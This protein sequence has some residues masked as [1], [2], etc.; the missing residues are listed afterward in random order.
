[1]RG[2][3]ARVRAWWEAAGISAGRSVVYM[4]E[5]VA[6][7][8]LENLVHMSR[9][10]FP[11]GYVTVA[12]QLPDSISLLAEDALRR[13]PAL[14]ALSPTELGNWWLES[15]ASAV[16]KV[17]SVVVRGA[18]NYL[19]NPQHPEFSLIQVEPPAIFH[20]DERLFA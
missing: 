16:L 10:D 15:Q 13:T 9:R 5:S 20:F 12:A 14:R 19:L 7:A 4:A 6:L 8:V 11:T 2:S 3:M 1:M 18:S 17:P